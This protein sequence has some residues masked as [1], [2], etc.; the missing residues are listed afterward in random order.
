[1]LVSDRK[2]LKATK[3]S[4]YPDIHCLY[5]TI[6]REMRMH[7]ARV[8][9]YAQLLLDAAYKKGEC[10]KGITRELMQYTE[11]MFRLH[12]IGRC[13]IGPELYNK[14]EKLTQKDILKISKH[15]TYARKAIDSVFFKP[16][17]EELMQYF[18]EVA[19]YH[20]ERF[21]GKGYPEMRKGMDIPFLARVCA[22]ADAY[23]GMVSWKTYKKGMSMEEAFAILKKESGKQFQ[24]ELVDIYVDVKEEIE[25][26][27]LHNGNS[28]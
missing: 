3:N 28:Q 8:A 11:N 20:H 27:D 13:F 25:L 7:M 26:Q 16:F 12:D 23:D 14:V 18:E 6:P 2:Y 15:T 24:P 4:M 19:F 1:M 10:P 17:P 5:N 22:I 21:D 9:G